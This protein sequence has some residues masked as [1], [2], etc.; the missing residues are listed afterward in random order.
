MLLNTLGASL[1][2]NPLTGKRTIAISHGQGRIR[3]GEY[4]IR[5]GQEF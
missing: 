3:V 5:A 1:L 4:K 2:G